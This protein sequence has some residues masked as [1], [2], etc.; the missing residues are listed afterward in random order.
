MPCWER[1]R[2]DPVR[3]A[4]KREAARLW[5]RARWEREHPGCQ[6]YRPTGRTKGGTLQGGRPRADQ[7]ARRAATELRRAEARMRKQSAHWLYLANQ[8]PGCLTPV[9]CKTGHWV[10][11]EDIAGTSR[12]CRPC[13]RA[14]QKAQ[15]QKNPRTYRA[16][17]RRAKHR[18]RA[19]E[20]AGGSYS[21]QEWRSILERHDHR[22]VRC[23][24]Q[25]DMTVDHILPLS[26]G[27]L[28]VA[29]NLQPM[30][31]RCNTAKGSVLTG[32]IQSLIPGMLSTISA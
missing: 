32:A 19:A 28:N 13:R 22:C 31:H 1:I 9:R 29:R 12:M 18:R 20:K 7:T 6:P 24:V 10:R 25:G 5:S 14:K 4:K 30:C 11:P 23:Q 16:Q 21:A 15:R 27:G 26:K 17:K 3:L 8:I 2:S